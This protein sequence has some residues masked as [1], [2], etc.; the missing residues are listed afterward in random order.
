MLE[1]VQEAILNIW[2]VLHHRYSNI[3][4]HNLKNILIVNTILVNA[5]GNIK[6]YCIEFEKK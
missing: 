4:C 2:H 3:T 6:T 1:L 5:L